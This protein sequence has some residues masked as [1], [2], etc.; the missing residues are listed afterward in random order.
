MLFLHIVGLVMVQ[1][2][3]MLSLLVRLFFWIGLLGICACVHS[4]RGPAHHHRRLLHD[5]VVG[6]SMV[7]VG[8][9][10]AMNWIGVLLLVLCWLFLLL[11]YNV[12]FR[13]S[14]VRP[15]ALLD[16]VT[17][18]EVALPFPLA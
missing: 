8:L 17:P 11:V 18:F 1:G 10:L 14:L 6:S 5:F 15:L 4:C 3:M 2:L 9:T 16:A 7:L 13:L 12:G